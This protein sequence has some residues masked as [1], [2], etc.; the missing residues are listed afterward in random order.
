MPFAG[1]KNFDACVRSVMKS[2]LSKKRAQA[3]CGKIQAQV[4]GNKKKKTKKKKRK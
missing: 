4:E 2:G 1:Y 3:Y